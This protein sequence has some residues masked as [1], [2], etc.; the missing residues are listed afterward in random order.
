MKIECKKPGGTVCLLVILLLV[1]IIS[2]SGFIVKKIT[3]LVHPLNNDIR[4]QQYEYTIESNYINLQIL[5][6][7]STYVIYRDTNTDNLYLELRAN[8]YSSALTPILESDGTPKK[9]TGN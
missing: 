9:Y 3:T 1:L 8:G 2:I 6:K 7:E 4:N 5:E